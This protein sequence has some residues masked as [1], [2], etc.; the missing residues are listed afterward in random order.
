MNTTTPNS[1]SNFIESQFP[2]F[3]RNEGPRFVAFVEAYYEQASQVD[4]AVYAARRIT[5]NQDVD[6]TTAVLLEYFRREFMANVP[7]SMLADKRLVTKH[8]RE[9]Y[10]ARGSADAYRFLFRIL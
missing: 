3:I 7:T 4:E 2:E 10:R 1:I 5:Q 6:E 9:F 8:I